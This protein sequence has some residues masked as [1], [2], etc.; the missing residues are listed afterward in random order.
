M[1]AVN[2][3]GFRLR[4]RTGERLHGLRLPFPREARSAETA[5]T[6]LI[7]MVRAARAAG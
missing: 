2:R 3:L 7:E 1:I 6:V 5:R 4:V